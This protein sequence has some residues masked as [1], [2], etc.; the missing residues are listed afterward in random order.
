MTYDE[1]NKTCNKCGE[2]KPLSEYY[3]NPTAA[4]SLHLSCKICHN[5]NK[6]LVRRLKK[7]FESLKPDRCECCGNTSEPLQV[8]HDHKNLKFRGFLCQSCNIKLG[9][10]GDS[11]ETVSKKG[12]DPM[13]LD[14]LTVAEFRMGGTVYVGRG[15]KRKKV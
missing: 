15:S 8:D 7:G 5:A 2:S 6:L 3:A 10:A 9:Y 11:Y 4:D 1:K 13:F 12:L 14:Y